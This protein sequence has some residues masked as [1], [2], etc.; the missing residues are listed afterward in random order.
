MAEDDCLYDNGR[1]QLSESAHELHPSEL[2]SDFQQLREI[3]WWVLVTGLFCSVVS[4][5]LA[6]CDLFEMFSFGNCERDSNNVRK[7]VP[8]LRFSVARV[9]TPFKDFHL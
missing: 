7:F 2:Q 9:D 3:F 6:V 4:V 8:S 5:L 1:S